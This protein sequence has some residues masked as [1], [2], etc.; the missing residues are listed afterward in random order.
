MDKEERKNRTSRLRRNEIL[1]WLVIIIVMISILCFAVLKHEYSF[2]THTIRISDVDGLIVGSPVYLMGVQIGFVTK[3]KMLNDNDEVLVKFRVSDKKIHILKGT[4]ATVEFTGLGGS[5]SLQLYPPDSA[6][7]VYPNLLE[8]N[9]DY[10]VV[11][12]PRRLRDCWSLLYQMYQKLVNIF[13]SISKFSDDMQSVDT[14]VLKEGKSNSVDFIKYT[15]SW[16]DNA[17]MSMQKYRKIID[18]Y[19][20]VKTSE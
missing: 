3:T 1:V 15:D 19:R 20:K 14:D 4:I 10:L 9:N 6:K 17:S 8:S 2:E 12:R 16:I 18:T 7:T 11:E 5:K 13:Y